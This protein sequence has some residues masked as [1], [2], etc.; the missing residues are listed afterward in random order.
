MLQVRANRVCTRISFFVSKTVREIRALFLPMRKIQ[1][2]RVNH[3]L[4]Q[5]SVDAPSTGRFREASSGPEKSL[6]QHG[7]VEKIRQTLWIVGSFFKE[8]KKFKESKHNRFGK[9]PAATEAKKIDRRRRAWTPSA[10]RSSCFFFRFFASSSNNFRFAF[11]ALKVASQGFTWK[12]LICSSKINHIL[13]CSFSGELATGRARLRTAVQGA[14]S[15]L[16]LQLTEP[17]E[18]RVAQRGLCAQAW[19]SSWKVRLGPQSYSI[20]GAIF[21][22]GTQGGLLPPVYTFKNVLF[23]PDSMT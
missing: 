2:K 15:Q 3:K 20:C 21:A 11:L 6:V 7:L 10:G 19:K 12:I 1:L 5:R 23:Q 14:A 16:Q 22:P 18:Q 4:G 17:K 9:R 13:R 8:A